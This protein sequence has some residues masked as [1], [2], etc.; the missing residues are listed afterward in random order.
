MQEEV[1]SLETYLYIRV[2]PMALRSE[3]SPFVLELNESKSSCL[4]FELGYER[5]L[6]SQT[7][8]RC[9]QKP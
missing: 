2:Q 3:A 6:E 7:S 4:R 1:E 9:I 5:E 8:F